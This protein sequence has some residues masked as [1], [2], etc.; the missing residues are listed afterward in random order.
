MNYFDHLITAA[1]YVAPQHVLSRLAWRIARCKNR[2]LKDLLIRLFLLRYKVDL[3]E[4]ARTR[5]SE[6]D[7]FNHFFTRA[8]RPDSRSLATPTDT[9]LCPADGSISQIGHVDGDSLM[10]A[11]GRYYSLGALLGRDKDQRNRFA[12]GSFAT[13]YLAPHNY[14]RVHAP[15]SGTVGRIRY[16][17]GRLFSVNNRTTRSV[18]QLFAL[19]ERLIVEIHSEAGDI[20]VILVGAMLVASMELTCCDVPGAIQAAAGSANPYLIEPTKLAAPIERGAELGRFNMGS[21]VILLA[22]SERLDWDPTLEHGISVR[23]GQS[24]GSLIAPDPGP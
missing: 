22:E 6:Y 1:Q 11:K 20:L 3:S 13:I 8:L 4:A 9:L 19:N 5:I 23:V 14:H 21:T 17:P 7:S 12:N 16:V 18:D 15:V 10:Q 2:Q 24:I